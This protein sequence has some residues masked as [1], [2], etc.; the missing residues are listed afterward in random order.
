MRILVAP[1]TTGIALEVFRSLRNE[2]GIELVGCG[3][4]S[5]R[6]IK[7]DLNEFIFFAEE[8]DPKKLEVNLSRIVQENRIDYVYICHDQWLRDLSNNYIDKDLQN[9]ILNYPSEN[10][11]ILLS[12]SLTYDA[13]ENHPIKPRVFKNLEEVEEFPIFLKPNE[14]QGSRGARKV[15]SINDLTKEEISEIGKSL[16]L[17]ELLPGHEFTV[18]CFSNESSEVLYFMARVRSRIENGV[19]VGT[20]DVNIE[21]LDSLVNFFSKK[22]ELSGAWFFQVK[23]DKNGII[24]LLE[25]GIRIAG[26]SGINRC[27]GVN[28]PLAHL[29]Q[30]LG[31]KIRI[32]KAS[33]RA[34]YFQSRNICEIKFKPEVAY[35]DFDD[36]L[37]LQN[38]SNKKVVNFL[39]RLIEKGIK[40]VILTRSQRDISSSL[41]EL[42]IGEYFE[43][44]HYV[45]I[46]GK[47]SSY[48]KE[49]MKF[50]FVDDSFSEREDVHDRFEDLGICLDPN[51]FET[52]L[53]FLE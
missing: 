26:A 20:S 33:V 8:K 45:P 42:G 40:L 7:M 52:D 17:Q 34:T 22:F 24:K 13:L 41:I 31:A 35:F 50:I 27:I 1:A 36:T 46:N 48:I 16:V 28:L 47:K 29:Y 15:E 9:R 53:L 51:A 14:G 5:I 43:E 38:A 2:K 4:D 30:K 32:I 44:I 49:N 3:Y 6:A 19:A 10:S 21:R 12:K 23:E 11:K 37:I 25:I 18:D 39:P